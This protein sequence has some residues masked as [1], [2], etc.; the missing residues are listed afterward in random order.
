MLGPRL[1]CAWL[2]AILNKRR[3]VIRSLSSSS[4]TTDVERYNLLGVS[5]ITL[6]RRREEFDLPVGNNFDDI[7]DDV[8][9]NLVWS[10]FDVLI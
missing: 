7:S 3:C 5:P 10:V 9:D 4:D 6:L 1:P 2:S 8:L